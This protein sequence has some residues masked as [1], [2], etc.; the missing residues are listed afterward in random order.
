MLTI[1]CNIYYLLY[2]PFKFLLIGQ[3]ITTCSNTCY[4]HYHLHKYLP[5]CQILELF[6]CKERRPLLYR[7]FSIKVES[8]FFFKRSFCFYFTFLK[9]WKHLSNTIKAYRKV[10]VNKLATI[11]NFLNCYN[12]KA[13]RQITKKRCFEKYYLYDQACHFSAL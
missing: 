7:S 13:H 5:D 1:F 9:H 6:V 3:N 2:N 10:S 12:L 11:F 4:I 8:S